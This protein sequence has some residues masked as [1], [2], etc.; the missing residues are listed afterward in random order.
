[1]S[2]G[3]RAPANGV[4][5]FL[6][7]YW[8][9]A[10]D[11]AETR[12]HPLAYH[13]ADVAACAIAIADVRP[14]IYDW[15]A[16]R[17]GRA[18]GWDAA[19][20]RRLIA[21]FGFA[22]DAGKH[23][24]GFRAQS[25][26]AYRAC[27]GENPPTNIIPARG[28][29]RHDALGFLAWLYGVPGTPS[30]AEAVLGAVLDADDL[31]AWRPLAS[32]AFGHHG[33]PT[34]PHA[35]GVRSSL[36]GVM[37]PDD[38]T[39]ACASCTRFREIVGGFPSRVDAA[40]A[41][42]VSI[43]LAGLLQVADWMGSDRVRFDYVEPDAPLAAYWDRAQAAARRAV[44][45]RGL[46]PARPASWRGVE[47]IVAPY[48]PTPMQ[49]AAAELAIDGPF[50]AILEDTMGS[51]KTEA[52][53]ALAARAMD[54][55]LAH[56]LFVGMP[57]TATA[58]GQAARQ[59]SLRRIIFA[60]G[61][62]PPSFAVAH[63]R[64]DPK[65]WPKDPDGA[66]SP[67][68]WIADER[69]L[70]LL[71]DLCVGTVD[72]ALLGVMAT[73]FAAVR[74]FALLGKVLVIDEVHAYDAYTLRLVEDLVREHA[75][76]G[77][78][79]VLLSATL[80]AAAKQGLLSA[81]RDGAGASDTGSD[82][83]T[84]PGAPYPA[85]TV[86]RGDGARTIGVDKA[87]TAPPDKDVRIVHSVADAEAALLDVVRR[88]GCAAWI[89]LTVDGAIASAIALA[90]RH[91]D[92][93]ALHSRMPAAQRSKIEAGLLARFGK[94]EVGEATTRAG[95]LV[96]AT[97]VI[98]ASLDVD[99]DL[100]VVDLR[101]MD[102]VLQALGRARRHRR[103]ADGR[104]LAP[105]S[106]DERPPMPMILLAPEPDAVIDE[107]WLSRFVGWSGAKVAGNAARAW[108]TAALVRNDGRLRYGAERGLVEA[109]ASSSTV[110]TPAPLAGSDDRAEATAYCHRDL[111]RNTQK[112][113][114]RAATG[115]VS[116]GGPPADDE[117]LETRLDE[118]GTVEV[119]LIDGTDG[120]APLG[121]GDSGW[122]DG[123]IRIPA[124]RFVEGGLARA[125]EIASE[126]KL[127][128]GAL[129]VPMRKEGDRWMHD[130][131]VM[132]AAVVDPRWGLCWRED[133]EVSPRR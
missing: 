132:C 9:K 109:A 1:M 85:L 45:E 41:K 39:A 28:D 98:A 15:I 84:D 94:G 96:V 50:L 33:H 14:W 26:Y 75:A 20:V 86:A 5:A 128:R 70:R 91:H 104:L 74:R 18:H 63:G 61:G 49:V 65:S 124:R 34:N 121:G 123:R 38:L 80:T 87:P 24:L 54:A 59:A 32:A 40:G 92:V 72:Q 131:K 93:T 3:V 51:G 77:G 47:P 52:A 110:P 37:R 133:E 118:V 81:F 117:V 119:H 71:A 88:G 22:H 120:Y 2:P 10:R 60:D 29:L 73:E 113:A 79:A 95:G 89:R 23:A 6:A 57:T 115:Y 69:R 66:P 4:E 55:G 56:G 67:E 122:S 99:F 42:L 53:V 111:A 19:A 36:R 105:G 30:L 125:G 116:D 58:D 112:A 90:K 31:K 8:G 27:T 107:D 114:L 35:K 97:S 103:A 62:A 7:R 25:D 16:D 48:P 100:V 82:E 68:S 108:R 127:P 102:E 101:G 43:P 64:S 106:S 130:G 129:A 11:P 83:A 21:V 13:Q 76:L 78:S 46:V 17:L 12:W 126:A 44:A